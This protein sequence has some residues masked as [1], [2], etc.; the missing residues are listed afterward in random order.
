MTVKKEIWS[1]PTNSKIL[2]TNNRMKRLIGK[3]TQ[4]VW[5]LNPKKECTTTSSSC[6]ILTRY[7]PV[8]SDNTTS[9]SVS[10]TDQDFHSLSFT[11]RKRMKKRKT[12]QSKEMTKKTRLKNN[13]MTTK[14]SL[15][16]HLQRKN[17]KSKNG[18]FCP[19]LST[20]LSNKD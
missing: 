12:K 9:A 18:D 19:N 13:P 17:V 16:T 1:F 5:W 4:V 10:L 11:S 8:S 6:S 3:N 14:C 7:I 20:V 2:K 15:L